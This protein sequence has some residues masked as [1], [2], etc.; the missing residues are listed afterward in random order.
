MTSARG[1]EHI[2]TA[3]FTLTDHQI[4]IVEQL[5]E[6]EM[7]P[8]SLGRLLEKAAGFDAA[9]EPERRWAGSRPARRRATPHRNNALLDFVIP[10]ASGAAVALG[11]GETVRIEQLADGQGVDLR[12]QELTGLGR[13]LSAGRT[14]AIHG[15]H[16]TVGATLWSTPPEVA[17]LR[18]VADTAP[19]HDLLFPA[20][21]PLEYEQ[22][23]GLGGHRS[24][25]EIHA[26]LAA[27]CALT[28]DADGPRSEDADDVLNLWL[29][30][31][32]DDA[33]NLRWWPTWCRRG[34][35]IDL[36][37]EQDVLVTLST[38]PDDLFGSSQYD[39]S[40][41]RVIVRG[42]RRKRLGDR[43]EVV[44]ARAPDRRHQVDIELSPM[45]GAHLDSVCAG[46]WLGCTTGAVA[47]ALLFRWYEALGGQRH[48]G[49]AVSSAGSSQIASKGQR[50][51]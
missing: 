14:R 7:T 31:A 16:P 27:R 17:L 36:Q 45:A 11:P 9:R 40:A 49:A 15:V 48:F 26:E 23:T 32:V 38:C 20:C 42:R 22:L 12:V 5:V 1:V 33:G 47:R 3:R 46:G 19:S 2:Q 29:P 43:R 44:L 35:R 4:A 30:T 28:P 41:V 50:S 18:I 8:G 10:P 37:A 21:T 6:G 25:S 13:R 51:T 39:P 24:C 34:D